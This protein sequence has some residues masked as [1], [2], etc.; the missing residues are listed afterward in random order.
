MTSSSIPVVLVLAGCSQTSA[1]VNCGYP[2]RDTFVRRASSCT[3]KN[4]RVCEGF[5]GFLCSSLLRGSLQRR[6]QMSLVL[7]GCIQIRLSCVARARA[8]GLNCGPTSSGFTRPTVNNYTPSGA[9]RVLDRQ[10]STGASHREPDTSA[11]RPALL[12]AHRS[13]DVAA[14]SARR[15]APIRRPARAKQSPGGSSLPGCARV[16]TIHRAGLA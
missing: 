3:K 15:L 6:A 4:E 14:D 8:R 12:Y 1:A 5:H 11:R 10:Q 9:D 2:K 7:T 13:L 16:P